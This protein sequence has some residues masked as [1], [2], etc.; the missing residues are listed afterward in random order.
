MSNWIVRIVQ[1]IAANE[2]SKSLTILWLI[3]IWSFCLIIKL[4]CNYLLF[5]NSDILKNRF[6]EWSSERS[7]CFY[8]HYGGLNSRTFKTI[9]IIVI[10]TWIISFSMGIMIFLNMKLKGNNSQN[11]FRQHLL[12][13]GLCLRKYSNN[14]E[15][16]MRIWS[17]LVAIDSIF[18]KFRP[19]KIREK[20]SVVLKKLLKQFF[21]WMQTY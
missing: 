19:L 15:Y 17:S 14:F 1:K 13:L 8:V 12:W 5:K 18:Q 11:T 3:R 7:W 10:F 9:I 4:Y 21:A 16:L 6:V 20:Y 2:C